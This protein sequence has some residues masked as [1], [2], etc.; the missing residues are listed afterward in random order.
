M[1]TGTVPNLFDLIDPGAMRVHAPTKVVLLCG[2]KYF[3]SDN[4]NG[5]KRKAAS[6]RDAF[7]RLS[8][9][10]P[11][12]KYR[13]VIPDDISF[14]PPTGP[15]EQLLHFERDL[16]QLCELVLLFTESPGSF[17]ELGAFAMVPEIAPRLLVLI[18]GKN[19]ADSSF[20][21]LGPV[22]SL[23]V[24]HGKNSVFVIPLDQLG[25]PSI[26]DI[27]DADIGEFKGIIEQPFKMRADEVPTPTKFNPA[28][29]GHMA[30]L[31]AGLIHHYGALT[32]DEIVAGALQ[33]ELVIDVPSVE[34]LLFCL[35]E[36]GWV[37]SE[38]R[39]F[40]TYHAASTDNS[41][42]SFSVK[43]GAANPSR[44]SWRAELREYWRSND[45][46][47]FRAISRGAAETLR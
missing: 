42:L 24:A 43:A 36:V 16:A 18:D 37:F 25:I 29:P 28:V 30:K 4:D 41:P 35:N 1:N 45:P 7:Y 10:E 21:K 2:G 32:S 20:I 38:T 11:F 33:L 14:A 3:V 27:G 34:K 8:P 19:Y 6:M 13:I 46:Q 5:V 15:Y 40:E 26:R 17:A 47:R 23:Q 39:G 31:I 44:S 12:S 22:R 9:F